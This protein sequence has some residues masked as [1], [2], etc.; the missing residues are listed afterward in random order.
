MASGMH[1]RSSRECT[2]QPPEGSQGFLD[3]S[4]PGWAHLLSHYCPSPLSQSSLSFGDHFSWG[5]LS[6]YRHVMQSRTI[7]SHARDH[8][9]CT[10]TTFENKNP[11]SAGSCLHDAVIHA[12]ISAVVIS[13]IPISS[14]FVTSPGGGDHTGEGQ[15]P[16]HRLGNDDL[17]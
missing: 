11:G 8:F 5:A 15:G 2:K 3:G 4:T 6:A 17:V 10:A 7:S 12:H 16:G 13:D 9:Y 1:P 14:S